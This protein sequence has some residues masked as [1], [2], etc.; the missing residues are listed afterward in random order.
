MDCPES[1]QPFWINRKPFAWPWCNLVASQRRPYCAS[2]NCHSTVG[3]VSRQWDAVDWGCVLC[4][5]R[6]HN[7]RASRSA[8]SRQCVFPFY[9]S[10]A[11]FFM[12]KHHITQVSQP[13]CSYIWLPVTSGFSQ[14]KNRLW[15]GGDFL[16]RGS[17]S[18]RAVNGVS[19]PNDQPHWRV[20]VH[21]RTV[22]SLTACQVISNPRDRFSRYSKWTDTFWDSPRM[23]LGCTWRRSKAD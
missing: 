10:R 11:G 7:D 12:A 1:F 23:S 22:R 13:P 9:S 14:T 5:C 2:V 16:I 3:L 6:I 18:T 8:S 17:H 4:D 19:L 20:T 21:G 15:N